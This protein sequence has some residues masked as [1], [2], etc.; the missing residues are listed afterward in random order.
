MADP[1]KAEAALAEFPDDL[2]EDMTA[3]LD[4]YGDL[5][6]NALLKIVYDKYPAYSKKSRLHK[7]NKAAPRK[8]SP[9]RRAKK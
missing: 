6:H 1:S 2:K 8:V 3:I 5:D 9:E 7:K 4:A